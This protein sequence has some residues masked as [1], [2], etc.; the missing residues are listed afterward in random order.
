VGLM[1]VT[2]RQTDRDRRT[3]RLYD[4]K[5]HTPLHA[6]VQWYADN[7]DKKSV[8]I[9]ANTRGWVPDTFSSDEVGIHRFTCTRFN[10]LH[11]FPPASQQLHL[12]RYTATNNIIQRQLSYTPRTMSQCI[13]DNNHLGVTSNVLF[14]LYTH[15]WW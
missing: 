8:N 4:S 2:D 10:D 5:G 14:N 7:E 15:L 13:S 6:M 12:Y 1:S 11:P 9:H 3:D